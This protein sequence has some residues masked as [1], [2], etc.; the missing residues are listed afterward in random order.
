MMLK[1]LRAWKA[2]IRLLPKRFYTT[3]VGQGLEAS[4]RHQSENLGRLN[5]RLAIID[6]AQRNLTNLTGEIVGLKDILSNKQ[7][8]G[9]YG[10]GRMEAIIRDGLPL[11]PSSSSRPSRT[12]RGPTASC[13]CRATSAGS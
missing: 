2:A 12:A 9:A 7:T 6:A 8:R 5:E 4:A 3:K 1:G 13:A 11:G 10:Q